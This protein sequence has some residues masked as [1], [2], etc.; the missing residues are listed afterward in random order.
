MTR[1]LLFWKRVIKTAKVRKLKRGHCTVV[2][3]VSCC[4]IWHC[5]MQESG[6]VHLGKIFNLT[7]STQ[8]LIKILPLLPLCLSTDVCKSPSEVPKFEWINKYQKTTRSQGVVQQALAPLGTTLTKLSQ[9]R[10]TGLWF[11]FHQWKG[12]SPNRSPATGTHSFLNRCRILQLVVH[13]RVK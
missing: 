1:T 2:A 6:L 13:K 3:L 5:R 7:A 12:A 11:C 9:Q 10:K 4:S 8:H